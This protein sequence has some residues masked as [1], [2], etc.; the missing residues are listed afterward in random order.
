[1]C[2]FA[3]ERLRQDALHRVSFHFRRVDNEA[4]SLLLLFHQADA[5]DGQVGEP[6]AE[7]LADLFDVLRVVEQRLHRYAAG[8]IDV[9]QALVA[10][11]RHRDGQDDEEDRGCGG[12]GKRPHKVDLR[13][14]QHA[15]AEEPGDVGFVDP[16]ALFGDVEDD[17]RDEDRGI[18]ADQDADPEGDGEAFDLVGAD[19]VQHGGRNH[20]GQ[21]GVDDRGAGAIEGVADGHAQRGPALQFLAQSLEHQH[22]VVHGHADGQG[23][24]G[25]AGQGKYGLHREHHGEQHQQVEK[26]GENGHDAGKTVV[27]DHEQRH[28]NRRNQHGEGAFFDRVPAEGGT[29]EQLADRVF[30]QSGGQAAG[31]QHGGQFLG[32]LLAETA[33]DFAPLVNPAFQS[34]RGIHVVVEDD[35]QPILVAGLRVGLVVSGKFAEEPAAGL[36]EFKVHAGVAG[37]VR[38]LPGVDQIR[39]G[40]VFVFADD[41]DFEHVLALPLDFA[42]GDLRIF[43][44]RIFH[45]GFDRHPPCAQLAVGVHQ[46]RKLRVVQGPIDQVAVFSLGRQ[47]AELQVSRRGD[48]PLDPLHLGFFDFGDDDFDLLDAVFAE[49]DFALAAGIDAF[50]D[51]GD[52]LVHVDRLVGAFLG[53]ID[54]VDEDHAPFQVDAQ[55]QRRS[56]PHDGAGRQQGEQRQADSPAVVGHAQLFAQI[57]AQ[58]ERH[59]DHADRD[60]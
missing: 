29:A 49:G 28:E 31:T 42:D 44:E 3:A 39:S 59:R 25:E 57:V 54:F 8:E 30:G 40:D 43:Q 11:D 14:S 17:P 16:A 36:V 34:G 60:Q 2:E 52:Q 15:G 9:Q 6:V 38:A 55:F 18:H 48:Q 5:A 19:D 4:Y 53:L 20:R 47:H 26:Q 7:F 46:L 10:V 45:A 21:V 12:E 37:L 13:A 50:P 35:A 1:M 23:N 58:K 51:G 24:A 32:L 27:G 41:E 33:G 22:V 56:H